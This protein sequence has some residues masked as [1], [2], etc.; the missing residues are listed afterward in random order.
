MNIVSDSKRV[1]L[2]LYQMLT[3]ESYSLNIEFKVCDMAKE[4]NMSNKHLN[5]CIHY[6]VSAGYIT[7]D[8][9][10]NNSDDAKKTLTMTAL[11][12]EKVE[13]EIV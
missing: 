9:A 10:F 2:G 5:L 11:G 3:D 7:G 13:K 12:I 8:I 6:L 1:L 4:V